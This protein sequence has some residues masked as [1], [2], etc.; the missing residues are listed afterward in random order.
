MNSNNTSGELSAQIPMLAKRV[1][2]VEDETVFARSVQKRLQREGYNSEIC[3]NLASARQRFRELSPDLVLL[4]MRLPD[5]SGLDFLTEIKSN[6]AADTVVLVMS[7]YGEV[8]DAVSAMK[9][10]ATDYLKKPVD[11]E[12]LLLN[13][14]KVLDR[15]ELEQQ[16]VNASKRH[17]HQA[18][19]VDFLGTCAAVE[20]VRAQ[21]RKV[22]QLGNNPA[23]LPPTVL[24][25][26]ETGTGKDVIARLLHALSARRDKPFVHVD[27]AS[28][29]KDLIEAELFGHE[30]GA[31]TSAHVSRTGLIEAAEDGVLFMDEIGEVPLDLQAKLL[32][33]LERRTVRRVGTTQERAARAWFIAATNRDIQALLARGEFRADLFYR[34]NVISILVPPLRERGADVLALARHFAAQTAKRYGLPVPG[35]SAAAERAISEYPWPGNVRELKHMIERAV[36]LSGGTE[37]GGDAIPRAGAMTGDTPQTLDAGMTLDAAEL[38]LIQQALG[39]CEGNV[40]RAARELGITRMALRYRMKKYG[41]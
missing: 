22:A 21:V 30:K 32:A 9:R 1:L 33:V 7:A 41:L 31:F 23:A 15:G 14:R 12:E 11:L 39:R 2:I 26:G 34:L 17:Q 16:V 37:L 38:A 6:P 18:G 27:C 8:D 35:I 13:V 24:I 3:P 19:G 5:G 10:G 40:S 29:P 25:L 4:D 28:L 36:L 20:A